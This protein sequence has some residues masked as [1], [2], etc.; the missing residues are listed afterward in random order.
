MA[1]IST[2]NIDQKVVAEDKWIGTDSNGAITKNFS[3]QGVANFLNEAGAIAIAGQNN[4]FFQT[5]LSNGR[6]DGT[7]SFTNGG[8]VNTAFN[9]LTT[10]KFSKYSSSG[11]MVL[12]YLQTLVNRNV[13]IAQTDN[14]NNFGVY[15]LL[16][17]TQDLLAPNFYDATF[18]LVE[19]HGALLLNKFY[20]FAVYPELSVPDKNYVFIQNA[21]SV[22]WT[23]NHNLNK[24]P[25][26]SVVNIN[27]IMVYGD[28]TYIDDNNLTIEFSAGF[29]GKAY[30][31]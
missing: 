30:L 1:R 31:N 20:V 13:F 25:S 27:N 8:G 10:I 14:V 22:L 26:V 16:T 2:Y 15:K 24:R 21:P 19:S 29:S 3:A 11:T 4:F 9:V 7:I 17:F 6:S 23:I 28:V 12:D 18:Q 5:D